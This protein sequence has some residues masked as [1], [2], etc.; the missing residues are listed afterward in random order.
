VRAVEG[1]NGAVRLV[2]VRHLDEAKAAGA[3]RFL[4]VSTVP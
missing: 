3:A 4:M 2:A 1:V